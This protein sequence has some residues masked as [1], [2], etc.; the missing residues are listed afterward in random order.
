MNDKSWLSW[1]EGRWLIKDQEENA[2]WPR[3]DIGR[4]C[5]FV[6]NICTITFL[7]IVAVCILLFNI[8]CKCMYSER[9]LRNNIII[10]DCV[11]FNSNFVKKQQVEQINR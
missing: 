10:L 1:Q 3:H 8:L 2:N 7:F 4:N 6:D 11:I 9:F 5:L